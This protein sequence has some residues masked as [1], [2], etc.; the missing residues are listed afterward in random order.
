MVN[1]WETLTFDFNNEATGTA[2]LNP[3]FTFDKLSIFFDFGT[4]GDDRVY[5]WDD[6]TFAGGSGG[7]D[8]GGGD[9]GSATVAPITFDDVGVAYAFTD[10]GGAMTT[11]GADPTDATNSVGATTKGAGSE[12]WAGTTV[13]AGTI[14]YPLSATA[15]QITVRVYSD[16][17][18]IPVRVKVEDAADATHTVET[19]AMTTMVN[20]WETLTFDFNNEATGTAALNPAF[21]FDKLSI[22]FD[23]GTAGD[24]RVYYWDDITFGGAS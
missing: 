5:Y 2:A 1:A 10:F 13:S 16:R 3:A 23:F 22:F 9:T 18:G 12:V 24:D 7:G 19:E 20:A 6:I 21:T 14:V 15:S 11:L 17:A 4:A 8:T